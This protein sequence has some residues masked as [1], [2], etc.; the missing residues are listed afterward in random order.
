ML[1]IAATTKES[2]VV[3]KGLKHVSAVSFGGTL[4]SVS[5]MPSSPL[6][7]ESSTWLETDALPEHSGLSLL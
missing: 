2:F 1:N 5:S 7:C 3:L 4:I 6:I